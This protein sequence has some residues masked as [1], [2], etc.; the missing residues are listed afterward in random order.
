M[1]SIPEGATEWRVRYS[2]HALKQMERRSITKAHVLTA[3]R[4]PG[5]E[6]PGW[7]GRW[8]IRA[9]VAGRLLCVG[10]EIEG[11]EV[12]IVTAYPVGEGD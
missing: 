2:D 5:A 10:Y 1:S 8:M 3:L 7:Q 4:N 9:L 6:Y 11:G 12:V